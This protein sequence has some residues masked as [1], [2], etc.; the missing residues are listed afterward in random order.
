MHGRGAGVAPTVRTQ[1]QVGREFSVAVITGAA[2]L[3]FMRDRGIAR[4]GFSI[5]AHFRECNLQRPAPEEQLDHPGG[6]HGQVGG[7]EGLG[8]KLPRRIG[9]QDPANRQRRAA[10]RVPQT[11][12]TEQTERLGL[13]IP[14]NRHLLALVAGLLLARGELGQRRALL[15]LRSPPSG[16]QR[17]G[18]GEQARIQA[19]A[20]DP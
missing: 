15:R 18:E 14:V 2:G 9:H 20:R 11:A 10:G 3:A 6:R 13:P 19:Q 16:G 12:P 1:G 7:E 8:R 5:V 17:R 4:D